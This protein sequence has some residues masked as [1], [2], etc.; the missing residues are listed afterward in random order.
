MMG[1]RNSKSSVPRPRAIPLKGIK[2]WEKDVRACQSK[3]KK[4]EVEGYGGLVATITGKSD[5]VE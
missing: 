1:T 3:W 5:N 4:G 2:A